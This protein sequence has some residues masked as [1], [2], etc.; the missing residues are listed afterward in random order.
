MQ[1]LFI[2]QFPNQFNY[3]QQNSF[4]G[5]RFEPFNKNMLG[6]SMPFDIKRIEQLIQDEYNAEIF[7]GGIGSDDG[8]KILDKIKNNCRQRQNYLREIYSTYSSNSFEV[9]QIKI[10]EPKDFKS[11]INYAI[12]EENASLQNLLKL[13]NE[14]VEPEI[15]RKI[16]YIFQSK[17]L[18]INYLIW[19]TLN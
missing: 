3:G 1:N 4:D 11:A 17:L 5:V 10:N 18:D 13:S 2:P 6:S 8:K 19:L 15:N 16:N 7:Y 9:K 12:Y 14:I